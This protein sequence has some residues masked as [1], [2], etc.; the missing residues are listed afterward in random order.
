M[1]F[2]ILRIKVRLFNWKQHGPMIKEIVE[3]EN[4]QLCRL[5]LHWCKRVGP[6]K[7]QLVSRPSYTTVIEQGSIISILIYCSVLYISRE[8]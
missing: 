2:N 8:W 5:E 6:G 3:R 7:Y 4:L 1:I